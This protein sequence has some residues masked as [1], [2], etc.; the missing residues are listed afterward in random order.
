MLR[1]YSA[2]VFT[3]Y[4][5]VWRSK[6]NPTEMST[7]TVYELCKYCLNRPPEKS[8]YLKKLFFFFLN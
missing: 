8:A 6:Q 1:I 5:E 7:E 4:E 2:L 3:G